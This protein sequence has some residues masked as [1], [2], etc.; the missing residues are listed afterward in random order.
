MYAL[1]E[2]MADYSAFVV[3]AEPLQGQS[4]EEVKQIALAEIEKVKKGE[5]DADLLTRYLISG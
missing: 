2:A 3:M 1:S 5:F 4:L